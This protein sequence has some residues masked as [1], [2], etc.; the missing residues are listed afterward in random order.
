[1]LIV[2]PGGLKTRDWKSQDCKT[3]DQI[4]GVEKTGRENTGPNFQTGSLETHVLRHRAK[5]GADRSYYGR[6]IAIIFRLF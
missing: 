4:A 3:W 6:D 1:M 2:L 5:F